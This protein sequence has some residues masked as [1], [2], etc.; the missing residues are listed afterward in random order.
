[1]ARVPGSCGELVQ[2]VID[3]GDLLITCPISWYSEVSISFAG[4]AADEAENCKSYAA[5]RAF[6]RNH[7]CERPFSLTI[8][9]KLP[10][11]KGMASSSAD[12]AAACAAAACAL[13]LPAA[14]DEIKEIALAIEPTDGV[15]FPGIVA[16]DHIR[17][18][19]L[20]TL[21]VPPAIKLAIFDCGGEID[22]IAFNKRT[23]LKVLRLEKQE[24]FA[25]AYALVREGI[26]GGN[27]VL[28][29]KGATI[30]ALANQKI[31]NKPYLEKMI[32]IGNNCGALGV[33]AAHS[34]VV[35]GVLFDGAC[36]GEFE[37]CVRDV[38]AACPGLNYLGS[39]GLVGGGIF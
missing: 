14:P 28:V 38:L 16:F 32:I 5:V 23:D 36:G 1:M 6:L 13:N 39:A 31:L 19:R 34:G 12:I 20:I 33:N 17:G 10:R 37:K 25:Q 24:E 15:F 11:G 7:G 22:T 9:S 35:A 21:G 8:A 2:G 27:P 4:N 18:E 3:G 29:A 30:S 26:A